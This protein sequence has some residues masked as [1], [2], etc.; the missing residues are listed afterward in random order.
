MKRFI[1]LIA[2]LCLA[3]SFCLARISHI[4]PAPQ[5][6]Q[7]SAETFALNRAVTISDP[8]ECKLLAR[9]LTEAG[10]SI[11]ESATAQVEVQLVS[12]IT[13]ASEPSLADFEKEAYSL[14][15]GTD[16]I[17]IKA[18]SRLG[19]VR[20]AQ[21]L[22]QMAED[23]AGVVN[24]LEGAT[25]TDWPAFKVR[26]FMHDVGRSFI[27]FEE[28]KN[29]I[30]LYS[31]FKINVFQWH[32]TE[33][34]AWRFE[35]KSQPKLTATS[36]MTRF[37]GKYYTQEQCK[38]LD[39]LAH[40]N[41]I[42][43][44][45][46]IDMPGHSEAFHRAMGFDMQTHEG[47]VVLKQVIDELVE[48]FPHSPYIH[49]GGDEVTINNV[50]GE[51]FLI[52]MSRYVH[53]KDKRVMWWNPTRNVTVSKDNGCDMAQCWST[54]GRQISGLPCIDCRYNYT[55]H[56][57]VFADLVGMYRSS[58]LY[59]KKGDAETAGFISCPWNDRK[60]PTQEDIIAQ[61]NVFAVTLASGE[62]AWRGG[63]EQYI[64]QCGAV[65][66]N[67]GSE[68]EEFCNWE[69][70]FLFHKAHSLASE[71]I[72]YV[73]QTNVRWRISDPVANEGVATA[74][75]PW[76]DMKGADITMPEEVA[77]GTKKYGW[78]LATGAGIYLNHTW[79][80]VVPGI[81]G[82]N[83]ALNQTAYA[84]TYI[85]SEEEQTVGAQI[86]FQNYGRSERDA[87]PSNGNWDRKGSDIWLNGQ[88]IAP[89]RWDNNGGANGNFEADLKNENFP[90]R[91]PIAVTLK[92]GWNKVFIKLPYVG[93][94]NVRLNKWLFTFVLTDT[95]GRNAI[96]NVIYSPTQTLSGEEPL[97]APA[98]NSPMVCTDLATYYYALR[99]PSR[100]NRYATSQGS[101]KALTG[102][103]SPTDASYWKLV[104][105]KD[106]DLDI[107]NYAD[108]SFVSPTATNNTALKTATKSPTK[109][110]KL[111]P[112]ST[113][114]MFIIVSGKTE[115]NQTTSAHSY[116]IFNWGDGT[117]TSD[118]GCQYEFVLNEELTSI[119]DGVPTITPSTE[120]GRDTYYD[121]TGRR[122]SP[123][124]SGRG[125]ILH[126]R[127]KVI[128]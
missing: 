88:R 106:G 34:Q 95:E 68:Y 70:R 80:T 103:T 91:K 43:I 21:T 36:S 55:N 35:V 13:G 107:V 26:G 101:G 6:V 105:R 92:K 52:A 30:L 87:A 33:N 115:W 45:P 84:Y 16:K 4:L 19:V 118:A 49:I 61:N 67:S 127:R 25:I 116:Q 58:I 97:P 122:T 83:Q 53:N 94:S 120:Y 56:F 104:P 50:D 7:T 85:Y 66:P 51:N 15:I 76:D 1:A 20:A 69:A 27:T 62:R 22:Q 2:L 12:S 100:E 102:T 123:A 41:G 24:A 112:A 32:M 11:N 110:W 81:W 124:Q 44:I 28:L 111:V 47:V 117:N 8:T 77:Y 114:G 128:R 42:Y 99:T 96:D 109:G 113:K 14:T 98:D 54:S 75:F 3:D 60:T 10:C 59:K 119:I 90:A 74:T 5:K 65:L 23:E 9:V 108:N 72:P 78:T 31:R 125:I 121:L 29:Q 46:E 48:C 57:D 38:E 18:V 126:Q 64:E 93:A 39:Q 86:E 82:L 37:A 63:G 79:P 89:P 71:P 73:K 40:E 17:S